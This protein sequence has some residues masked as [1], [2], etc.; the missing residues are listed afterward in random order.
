MGSPVAR[1]TPL[2]TRYETADLPVGEKAARWSRRV[3]R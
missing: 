2:A 3:A 1:P